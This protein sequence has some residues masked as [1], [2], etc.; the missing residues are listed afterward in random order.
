MIDKCVECGEVHKPFDPE[1]EI[2]KRKW[3]F[4]LLIFIYVV[5]FSS[6]LV[7]TYFLLGIYGSFVTLCCGILYWSCFC[8][9]ELW[10]DIKELKMWNMQKS[11]PSPKPPSHGNYV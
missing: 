10:L 8:G 2:K 6:L 4:W 5:S 11:I 7:C 9:R 1:K 3:I